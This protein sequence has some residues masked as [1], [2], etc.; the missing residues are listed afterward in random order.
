MLKMGFATGLNL[1]FLTAHAASR[2]LDERL[3]RMLPLMR[4]MGKSAFAHKED[5]MFQPWRTHRLMN[6]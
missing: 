1:M 6:T 2:K 4:S 3:N 5:Y